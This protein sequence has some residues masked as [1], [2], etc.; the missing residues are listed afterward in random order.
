MMLMLAMIALYLLFTSMYKS[1]GMADQP[2]TPAAQVMAQPA[3]QVVAPT[4]VPAV[5]GVPAKAEE[6]VV[7]VPQEEA[8]KD[9][10]IVSLGKKIDSWFK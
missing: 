6:M 8:K 7:V 2:V 5:P 9:N 4:V 10:M 3:A 1:E